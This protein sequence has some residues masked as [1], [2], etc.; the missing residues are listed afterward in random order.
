[1][2]TVAGA[3]TGSPTH[4]ATPACCRAS[5]GA[6]PP[7]SHLHE[8]TPAAPFHNPHSPALDWSRVERTL[9]HSHIPTDHIALASLSILDL[10]S[11]PWGASSPRWRGPCRPTTPPRSPPTSLQIP[12]TVTP[13]P[14]LPLKP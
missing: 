4:P 13:P 8:L 2:L 5:L 11:R 6:L 1:V 9:S 7:A 3:P 10:H 12:V 14:P